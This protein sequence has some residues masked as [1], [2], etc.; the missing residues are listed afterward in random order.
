MTTRSFAELPFE[1]IRAMQFLVASAIE[2][3]QPT[4]VTV[5]DDK[6]N[7]LAQQEFGPGQGEFSEAQRSA[8]A[9]QKEIEENIKHLLE[10]VVGFGKVRAQAR[11]E[12]DTTVY[13]ES[14][15]K[16]DPQTVAVR[17]EQRSERRSTSADSKAQGAPGVA[18]N[19]V[20][21]AGAGQA[22]GSQEEETESV[23]TS[24][25]DINKSMKTV[26]QGGCRLS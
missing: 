4:A 13:T 2:G 20:G 3:L 10:P 26:C 19:V 17:S 6:G 15:E 25:Y 24:I 1:K 14:S 9:I 21:G 12:L 23:E 5:I 7:M 11:V 22:G 16:F 18:A 8:R